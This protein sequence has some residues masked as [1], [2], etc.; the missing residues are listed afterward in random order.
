[1]PNATIDLRGRRACA[2]IFRGKPEPMPTSFSVTRHPSPQGRHAPVVRRGRPRAGPL[3]ACL[4]GALLLAGCMSA[5]VLRTEVTRFHQWESAEPRT[6]AFRREGPL[7][8]TLEHRSYERLIARQLATLGFA[9]AEPGVARYQVSFSYQAIGE[10]GR[11]TEYWAPGGFGPG[12]AFGPWLGPRPMHPYPYGRFD[13]LWAMPPVPLTRDVTMWRH[14]LR[15]DL[16]DTRS[17][18]PAGRKVYESRAVAVAESEAM[19]RLMPGLV[20]AVLADFPG[21]S[22]ETRRLE[23]PLPEPVR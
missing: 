8:Q 3:A 22:G 19:P 11:I 15:L 7:A 9:E 18:P 5:P 20:A 17:D 1:M 10:P 2:R 14:E 4:L 12:Y 21:T 6:V 23:V 16:F 13:P